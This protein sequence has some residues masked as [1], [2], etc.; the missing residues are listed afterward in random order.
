MPFQPTDIQ[1]GVQAWDLVVN[2]NMAA[3][4]ARF[5]PRYVVASGAI[6]VDDSLVVMTGATAAQ[7]LTLPA[8]AT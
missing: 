3:T 7:T 2:D 5:T 4:K 8:A 1:S 6:A